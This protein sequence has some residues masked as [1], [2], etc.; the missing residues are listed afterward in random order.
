M[1]TILELK[2]L[3]LKRK[4]FKDK[5]FVTRKIPEKDLFKVHYICGF[6]A[7]C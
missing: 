6:L 4:K 2:F 3:K 5:L 7:N 1:L